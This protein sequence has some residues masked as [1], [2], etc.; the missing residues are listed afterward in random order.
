MLIGGPCCLQVHT[1]LSRVN[2]RCSQLLLHFRR[3]VQLFTTHVHN[4]PSKHGLPG[5]RK[6]IVHPFAPSVSG[7][8]HPLIVIGEIE[9]GRQDPAA[10]SALGGVDDG[11]PHHHLYA[12]RMFVGHGEGAVDDKRKGPAGGR[13]QAAV[14][15]HGLIPFGGRRCRN[16]I[17]P[18]LE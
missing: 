14:R 2:D 18:L 8:N 4:P 1:R 6:L 5:R 11:S 13:P 10:D 16:L 3:P 15:R 7:R 17:G 9:V 12:R